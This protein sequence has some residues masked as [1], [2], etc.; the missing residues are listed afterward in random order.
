MTAKKAACRHLFW[1]VGSL[2]WRSAGSFP[3]NYVGWKVT[4]TTSPAL[5]PL[6]NDENYHITAFSFDQAGNLESTA[7]KDF[8]FRIDL[9][10]YT[11]PT[12]TPTATAPP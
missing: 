5:P 8:E 9:S 6:M 4:S 10:S 7:T 11:P 12:A 3:G 2:L 1:H